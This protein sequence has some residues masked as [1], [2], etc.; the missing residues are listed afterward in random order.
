MNVSITR[1][2]NLE[3]RGDF[4][5]ALAMRAHEIRMLGAGT[6]G[7]FVIIWTILITWLSSQASRKDD[8]SGLTSHV[9]FNAGHAPL[10]GFWA[11]GTAFLLASRARRPAP[12]AGVI[13]VSVFLTILYG[14]VDELH[15][16]Y[17][18]GRTA[19]WTD[20]V[21]DGAGAAL[22]LY[23]ISYAASARSTTSGIVVRAVLAAVVML[24]SGALATAVDNWSNR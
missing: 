22:A 7:A 1:G 9:L 10:Y 20:V 17:V 24:G 18:P 6:L 19:S 23:C 5:A 4:A 2:R 12:G 3:R 8:P 21:T 14:A 11:A 15:Q 13:I 16:S